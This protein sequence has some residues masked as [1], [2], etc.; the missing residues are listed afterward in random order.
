MEN[1]ALYRQQYSILIEQEMIKS[2]Y[3]NISIFIQHLKGFSDS[4]NSQN[5][6]RDEKSPDARSDSATAFKT[7]IPTFTVVILQ[8][9]NTQF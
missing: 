2:W 5:N 6:N 4:V 9:Q 3:N 1:I 8:I 7:L